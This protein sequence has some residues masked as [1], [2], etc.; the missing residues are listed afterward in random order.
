MAR[1]KEYKATIGTISHGTMLTQDLIESF[2]WEVEDCSLSR[3]ARA[4]VRAANKWLAKESEDRDQSEGD[5]ILEELFDL[6]DSFAPPY[7]YFGASEGDGSDFGFW[8]S[9]D[10]IDELPRV[11][12]AEDAKRLG[13]DCAY[14]SDHGNVTIYGGNGKVLLELV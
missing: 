1:R 13:E 8:P 9:N 5:N 11:E 14:V 2:V 6:M 7:C 4:L 3:G 12:G 10:A